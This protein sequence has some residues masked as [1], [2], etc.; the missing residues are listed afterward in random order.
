MKPRNLNRKIV[1]WWERQKTY[2]EWNLE[3]LERKALDNPTLENMTAWLDALYERQTGH[4]P[5]GDI[6]EMIHDEI[7]NDKRQ[8][9]IDE[10]NELNI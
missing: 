9:T 2:D 5:Y 1:P 10:N 8:I 7:L 4:K 3:N 6:D